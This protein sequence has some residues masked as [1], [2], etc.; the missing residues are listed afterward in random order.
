MR[1]IAKKGHG[2]CLGSADES[3][4]CLMMV[5]HLVHTEGAPRDKGGFSIEGGQG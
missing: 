5:M 2:V 3:E 1:N 4:I